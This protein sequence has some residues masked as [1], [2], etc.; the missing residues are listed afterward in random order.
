MAMLSASTNTQQLFV[1]WGQLMRLGGTVRSQDLHQHHQDA[2]V[3]CNQVKFM[4]WHWGCFS[5]KPSSPAW[6]P[7]MPVLMYPIIAAAGAN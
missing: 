2:M 6:Q 7:R 4:F 3:C 5:S 1:A